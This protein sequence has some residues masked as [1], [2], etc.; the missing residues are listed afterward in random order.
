MIKKKTYR[1]KFID[2]IRFMLS[3]LSS[4]PDDLPENFTWVNAKKINR[5]FSMKMVYHFS[6]IETSTKPLQSVCI[7]KS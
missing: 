1:M 7:L 6:T 5:I 2:I 3:S 4:L